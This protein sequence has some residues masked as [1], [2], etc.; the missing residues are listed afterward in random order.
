MI[1]L[2]FQQENI[3][4][5][6]IISEKKREEM[7]THECY[8]LFTYYEQVHIMQSYVNFS[9]M[10]QLY[11]QSNKQCPVVAEIAQSVVCRADAVLQIRPPSGRGDF[12]L[13]VNM[14]S[15]SIP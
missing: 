14:G 10:L 4:V 9:A 3:N 1:N 11:C 7:I 8:H 6:M 13:V 12:P 15:D 2:F 5:N